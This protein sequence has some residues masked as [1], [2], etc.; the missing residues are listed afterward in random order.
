VVT[1]NDGCAGMAANAGANNELAARS[2][3]SSMEE[4]SNF[5]IQDS[6]SGGFDGDATG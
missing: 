6:G 5:M 2:A 4:R 3:A 1:F